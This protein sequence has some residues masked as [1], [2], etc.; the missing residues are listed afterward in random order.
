M[1]FT[2]LSVNVHAIGTEGVARILV[3][4]V[5]REGNGFPV[6]LHAFNSHLLVHIFSQEGVRATLGI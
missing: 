3:V 1:I 5:V 2:K 4:I 6:L